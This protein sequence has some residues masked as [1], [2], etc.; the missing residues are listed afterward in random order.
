MD[1]ELY[2]S[3]HTEAQLSGIPVAAVVFAPARMFSLTNELP[4]K[5][6]ARLNRFHQVGALQTWSL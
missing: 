1:P 4:T 6:R 5:D 3:K 2:M